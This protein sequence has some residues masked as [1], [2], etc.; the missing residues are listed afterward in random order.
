[1]DK[2]QARREA[3]SLVAEWIDTYRR[4]DTS[5]QAPYS[6][7]DLARVNQALDELEDQLDAGPSLFFRLTPEQQ[8][9]LPS[10]LPARRSH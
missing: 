2:R 6:P 7:A 8:Q 1:M 4:T 3:R 9:A 10:Q 5:W